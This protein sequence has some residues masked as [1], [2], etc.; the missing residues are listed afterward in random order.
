MATGSGLLLL[1][2]VPLALGTG[3][4]TGGLLLTAA[5]PTRRRQGLVVLL[6]GDGLALLLLFASPLWLWE[7]NESWPVADGL[8]LLRASGAGQDGG[9]IR[10]WRQGERPSLSWYAGQRIRPEDNINL[11]PGQTVWLLGLESAAAPDLSC[12][13]LRQRGELRLERC[14]AER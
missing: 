14:R 1:A 10:L 8:A 9:E 5:S 11:P 6:L 4:L 3:L 2:A 7:L 12:Q 13:T